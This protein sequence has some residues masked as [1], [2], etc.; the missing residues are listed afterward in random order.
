VLYAVVSGVE[1]TRIS[2]TRLLMCF[3]LLLVMSAYRFWGVDGDSLTVMLHESNCS[4]LAC[5]CL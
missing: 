3:G 5:V 1:I 4:G 2:T